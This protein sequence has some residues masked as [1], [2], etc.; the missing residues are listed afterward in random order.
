MGTFRARIK[1][2]KSGSIFP[3]VRL[4]GAGWRSR[5]Q[6]TIYV[7]GGGVR[8]EARRRRL[9]HQ[10]N[11]PDGFLLSPRRYDYLIPVRSHF[12]RDFSSILEF[13]KLFAAPGALQALFGIRLNFLFVIPER[14]TFSSTFQFYFICTYRTYPVVLIKLRNSK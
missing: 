11:R 2:C 8:R 14:E 10:S 6:I 5:D 13:A 4:R 1:M 12:F 3:F 7:A 9:S